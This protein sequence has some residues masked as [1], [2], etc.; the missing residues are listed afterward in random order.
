MIV[1]ELENNLTATNPKR[2]QILQ[3]AMQTFLKHGYARTSMDQVAA[4]AGVSK[5]TIYSHFQDKKGLFTALIERVTA[6]RFEM[7]TESLSLS[8]DPAAVLRHLAETLL[9]SILSDREYI[10]FMRV[11]IGESDHFP[12]LAQLFVRSL[13]KKVLAILSHYFASH[14][15]LKVPHPE[16]TARI[17]INSLIGFVL[18]QE[19]LHGKDIMPMDKEDLIASLIFLIT[20]QDLNS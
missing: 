7:V 15:E 14:R 5:N 20:G 18:T 8:E 9:D 17:F 12:E 10:S 19:I 2:Q 11:L 16:A 3:G 4:A 13:P 1:S 6:R